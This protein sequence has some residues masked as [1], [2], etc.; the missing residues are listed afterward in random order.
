MLT[1]ETGVLIL[2]SIL[3][4]DCLLLFFSLLGTNITK[5]QVVIWVKKSLF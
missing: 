4:A 2:F 3:S 5:E 1:K